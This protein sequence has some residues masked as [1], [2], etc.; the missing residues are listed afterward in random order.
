MLSEDMVYF[1]T[2]FALWL[3]FW[4]WPSLTAAQNITVDDTDPSIQ[5]TG[6]WDEGQDCG[7]CALQ[8]D[9]NQMYNGTW[10][11]S[12][13]FPASNQVG[14]NEGQFSVASVQFTGKHHFDIPDAY[15]RN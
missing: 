6:P 5:Y 11:D 13:F 4:T 3:G 9:R 15:C 14:T 1:C 7:G 8:P 2:C 12:T 10:H